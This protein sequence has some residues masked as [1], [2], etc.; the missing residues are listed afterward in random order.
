MGA[1]ELV[2]SGS[3][4]PTLVG[5][6]MEVMAGPYTDAGVYVCYVS[7]SNTVSGDAFTG[8]D[9]IG[10]GYNGPH[11]TEFTAPFVD[12][13]KIEIGPAVTDGSESVSF[14]GRQ[15][16]GSGERDFD[17]QVWRISP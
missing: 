7:M 8:V 10:G 6:G 12:N 13:A 17:W 3:F 15:G 1:I 9:N 11:L 14:A 4:T 5:G 2:D 16:T